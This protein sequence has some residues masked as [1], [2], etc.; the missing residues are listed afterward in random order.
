MLVRFPAIAVAVVLLS[1]IGVPREV[2][3]DSLLDGAGP[4][5]FTIE[6]PLEHL[7]EI[8]SEDENVTV[9]GT[10]RFKD[11]ASGADVVLSDVAVSVR[12]HTSRR[13]TECTFPKL[14]LKLKGAGSL[15][16]GTHCGE[17]A[18]H[19]LS[20]KY[21]RLANEKSPLRE[22]LVY[23]LLRAAETPTLRTRPARVTYI[24]KAHT[25]PLER[26]ALLLEDDDDAMKRVGGTAEIP[27]ETFGNV[28]VRGA[29]ADAARIAFAQ[30]MIGNFDWCLK[31]SPDDIYRCNEPKP[32][33]NVLAFD[34]GGGKTS[35][36][37]KDFDLA[38]M[39][40]GRHTWFDKVWNRAVVGSGSEIEIEVLSQVQRT[41]SLFPRATLDAER[42]HFAARKTA[43]YDAVKAAAVDDKGRELAR[44]YLNAFYAAITEDDQYYRP[45]VV[46]TDVQVFLDA[47]G[48]REACGPK[49][50]MRPGTPV[51]EIGRDGLMSQVIVLD[52]MWRWGSRN[53][54][55]AVQDGPVWIP[56]DAIVR[57]FPS[58]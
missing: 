31:F 45:I 36:L 32:L 10:V 50:V 5:I 12:G 29:T 35:L 25:E 33:W 52:A 26:H 2:K 39:V 14:K 49:D 37:M 58:R 41:R 7:F 8:G 44:A 3:L 38:G 27:L 22:A 48:T 4:A 34:H 16:I 56:T 19:E 47:A 15:K 18:D 42:R 28:A 54:C 6:A 13:E 46:R 20:P 23:E 11:P 9:P 30:A 53:E 17:G 24:D 21:G 43:I 51:N 1:G 57:N 55:H 40:V